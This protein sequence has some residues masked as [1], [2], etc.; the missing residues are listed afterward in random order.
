LPSRQVAGLLVLINELL[1]NAVRHGRGAISISFHVRNGFACLG[2]ADEGDG[3]P[4]D[5][6][7][8]TSGGTGLEIVESI[9]RLDLQGTLAYATG[10]QG[11][12]RVSLE[13]QPAPATPA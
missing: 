3:F 7:P 11:G 5:F 10:P 12:A 9:G 13:F 1:N 2:V 6:D 4:P 8:A